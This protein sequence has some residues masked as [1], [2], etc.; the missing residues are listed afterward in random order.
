[1]QKKRLTS[2]DRPTPL[3]DVNDDGFITWGDWFEQ[4]AKEKNIPFIEADQTP[5]QIFR[6]IS[7]K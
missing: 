7:H 3:M 6:I 1:M 4:M 2:P 5:E